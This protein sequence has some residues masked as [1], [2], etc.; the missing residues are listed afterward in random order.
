MQLT[1]PG[2]LLGSLPLGSQ[3]HWHFRL[4]VP[5]STG[6]GMEFRDV[7]FNGGPKSL[8]NA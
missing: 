2:L 3:I 7:E 5:R 4:V 6:R 8:Y 1:V